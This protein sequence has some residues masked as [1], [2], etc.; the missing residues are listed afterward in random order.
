M[1]KQFFL[2]LS[3]GFCMNM[4]ATIRTVSNY[5]ASLA[6]YSTIQAAVDASASGDSIY[7]HGSPTTY[8]S[9]TITNK[10]LTVLGPGWAP[11]KLYFPFKAI[12]NGMILDGIG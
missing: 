4:Y 2:C 3:L 10:R 6:Q 12:V 9:F 11:D 5:P 1:M 7:V 8:A